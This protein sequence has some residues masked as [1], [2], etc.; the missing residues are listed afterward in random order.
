[1][2]APASLSVRG[3]GGVPNRSE[4]SKHLQPRSK[5]AA[6]V[7][8]NDLGLNNFKVER[9]MWDKLGDNARAHERTE[10]TP[11]THNERVPRTGR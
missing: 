6:A 5:W 2:E 7:N 10:I 11:K 8:Q 3:P 1:M 9:P 4:W